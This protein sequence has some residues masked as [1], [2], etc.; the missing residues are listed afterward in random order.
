M[1]RIGKSIHLSRRGV[2]ET[3][4]MAVSV[5]EL[6]A[7]PS[8]TPAQTAGPFYPRS[9]PGEADAD[10]SRIA[11]ARDPAEGTVIEVL[12]RV[13]SARKGPVGNATV[14][15]WQADAGGIYNHPR[16]PA[17]ADRDRHFQGYGAVL[18]DREGRFLFRTIR[19][20]FY[21]TGNGLRTPHI[22]FRVKGSDIGDLTTQMYFPGEPMNDR[23][24]IYKG[25]G[26]SARRMAATARLQAGRRNRF[27]FDIVLD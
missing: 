22:H 25:L 13:L 23:D 3:L 7:A 12:G 20:R 19:P 10:L 16:D 21:D 15:M 14:E 24:P 11:G 17:Y 1:G 4:L 2:L 9:K 27:V 8:L 26:S 18:S 6:S 5:R